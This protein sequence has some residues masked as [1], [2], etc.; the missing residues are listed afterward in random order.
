MLFNGFYYIYR[1][2][3]LYRDMKVVNVFIICDG[4]LKLVDFG[5]VWVFSLVKNSQFNCYINCVVIFWYWFLELL[6][7]EWDYGFFIDLWG[8]GCIMVEMW[9]CSFIMQ[10]NMEQY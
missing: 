6:F 10:G 3:I 7:G 9:I 1:N 5:L 4:V 2:K 8:V